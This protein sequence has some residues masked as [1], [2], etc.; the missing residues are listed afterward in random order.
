MMSLFGFRSQQKKKSA[1]EYKAKVHRP[2]VNNVIQISKPSKPK[3]APTPKPAVLPSHRLNLLICAFLNQYK[4]EHH[5]RMGY[6]ILNELVLRYYGDSKT[7]ILDK[8]FSIS[9]S[10]TPHNGLGQRISSESSQIQRFD[11]SSRY[12][13]NKYKCPQCYRSEPNILKFVASH[14]TD[15]KPGF[16][17]RDCNA[18]FL[19]VD[20]LKHHR[21]NGQS[22]SKCAND[23]KLAVLMSLGFDMEQSN[24]ALVA[25]NYVLQNAALGLMQ[26]Q[27]MLERSFTKPLQFGGKLQNENEEKKESLEIDF[28]PFIEH[29]IDELSDSQLNLHKSRIVEYLRTKPLDFESIKGDVLLENFLGVH[30]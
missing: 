12:F 7:R 18:T 22:G 21:I 26:S 25:S 10:A 14:Q 20:Q 15:N 27:V 13:Y 30:F 8:Y 24:N 17:C 1:G 2:H 9:I 4:G 19:A 11:P 5:D 29:A 6:T 3:S 23:L 16:V 28:I